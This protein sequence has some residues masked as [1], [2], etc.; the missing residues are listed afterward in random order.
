M[1]TCDTEAQAREQNRR[2]FPRAA[3]YLDDARAV[4]GDEVKLTHADENG[5]TVGKK[6][7]GSFM[8]ADQWQRLSALIEFD[9]KLRK[10]K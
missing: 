1:S 3:A 8:F 5:K 6:L 7:A 9:K 4:F 2:N 10:K